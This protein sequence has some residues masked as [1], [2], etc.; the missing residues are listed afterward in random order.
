M[1]LYICDQSG[2]RIFG[3][4]VTLK[5]FDFP[6]EKDT[7]LIGQDKHFTNSAQLIKWFIT[8]LDEQEKE[9]KEQI[10]FQKKV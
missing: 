3:E 9:V 7:N 5:N 10:E 8:K 2:Q 4:P 6:W 1:K